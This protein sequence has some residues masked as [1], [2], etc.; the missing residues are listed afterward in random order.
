MYW[1]LLFPIILYHTLSVNCATEGNR[2]N[3]EEADGATSTWTGG[4]RHMQ[5]FLHLTRQCLSD[6]QRWMRPETLEEEQSS[7]PD[8]GLPRDDSWYPMHLLSDWYSRVTENKESLNSRINNNLTG[9]QWYL[10]NRVHGQHLAVTLIPPYLERFLND[11]KHRK[12]LTLSFHGWTGTGKNFVARIIAENLYKN[13]QRKMCVQVFIP[14][15]HF[16]HPSNLEAYKVLLGRQIKEVLSHC[17]QP[18]FLFD[19]ADKI[20]SGLISSLLPFLAPGQ[21]IQSIFIFLSIGSNAINEVT[22]NFWQ[23]GRRREEI[24]VD[25]LD[26]PLRAAIRESQDDMS[27]LRQLMEEDLIDSLVPFLPLERAHVKLCAQDSFVARGL[28]YT[29]NALE[30]VTQELQFLPQKEKLFSAQGCKLV[31]QRINLIKNE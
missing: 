23:A 4:T 24:T 27:L 1:S 10:D 9:L 19:E 14:Q 7:E 25:D 3:E 29:E 13:G 31:S 6:L 12:S 16:P 28:P 17:S 2:G 15:L 20:P 26:R 21:I 18:M 30:M 8:W 5:D 11:E 22:L